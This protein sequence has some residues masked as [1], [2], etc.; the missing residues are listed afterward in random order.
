[1]SIIDNN[2][3]ILLAFELAYVAAIFTMILKTLS[4]SKK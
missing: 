2:L 3:F 4:K 1:M